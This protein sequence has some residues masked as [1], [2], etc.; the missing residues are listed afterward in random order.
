MMILKHRNVIVKDGE[1]R[2]AFN[3]EKI[4]GPWVVHVMSSRR[5]HGAEDLHWS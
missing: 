5:Q 3:F 2:F 1:L 4:V